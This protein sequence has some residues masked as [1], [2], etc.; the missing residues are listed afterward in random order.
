MS[1]TYNRLAIG[2]AVAVSTC[3][4]TACSS[5]TPGSTQAE[6]VA[7]P[8]SAIQLNAAP[9]A[10][11]L[12]AKR[13]ATRTVTRTVFRTRTV[14]KTATRT[15]TQAAAPVATQTVTETVAPTVTQTV[16]QTVTAAPSATVTQAPSGVS[17][18]GMYRV[19]I[20]IQPGTYRTSGGD[21]CYWARLSGADGSLDSII[22]NGL[23][24]ATAFVTIPATDKYFETNRCG[25]WERV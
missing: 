7:Q 15:V 17:G 12:A 2:I 10:Q 16:T 23:P 24:T 6:Q 22:A 11:V 21:G 25:A 5:A 20:D 13:A 4:L 1:Q 14:T 8:T 3:S 18:T 19:G 9:V